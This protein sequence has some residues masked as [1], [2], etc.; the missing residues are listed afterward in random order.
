MMK[1]EFTVKPM[2]GELVPDFLDFFDRR[3]F[4]DNPQWAHCY[5]AFFHHAGTTEQWMAETAGSNRKRAAGLIESG[6]MK[7]FLAYRGNE[8]AGWCNANV[9]SAF[10]FNKERVEAPGEGD[11]GTVAVVCFVIAPE[12][13]RM[14][15]A[16]ALLESVIDRYRGTSIRCI[17]AYPSTE[18]AKDSDHYHGPLPLYLKR[19]FTVTRDLGRYLVVDLPLDGV[20][21]VE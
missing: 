1:N 19:G 4:S 2:T 17:E 5:C 3:A 8:P 15:V 7:G 18:G 11:D 6:A 13:R 12:F 10:C 16:G 21:E 20:V 14:G 9:K